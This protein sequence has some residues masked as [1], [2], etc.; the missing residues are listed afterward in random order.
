MNRGGVMLLAALP[1]I[2]LITVTTIS[3]RNGEYG[4]PAAI[5]AAVAIVAGPIMYCVTSAVHSA[6]TGKK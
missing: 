4:I 2:G 5:G 1:L 3:F 6:R